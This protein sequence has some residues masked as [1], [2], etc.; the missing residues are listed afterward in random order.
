[1]FVAQELRKKSIAAYLLYMWQVEDIIRAYGC[2]LSRI[3]REYISK[4][5]YTDEQKDELTD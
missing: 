4:F 3:K 2:Q 5:N 1:M